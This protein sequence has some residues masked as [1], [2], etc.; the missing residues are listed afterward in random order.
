MET[1]DESNLRRGISDATNPIVA[2]ENCNLICLLNEANVD[3]PEECSTQPSNLSQPIQYD[4]G[5]PDHNTAPCYG[6][7]IELQLENGQPPVE[8]AQVVDDGI[9]KRKV[10][11]ATEIE[12]LNDHQITENNEIVATSE[13]DNLIS[14][15]A[16]DLLIFDSSTDT[17]GCRDQ[18]EE[19]GNNDANLSSCSLKSVDAIDH[20]TQN[21][22]Q[23]PS[24]GNNSKAIE[25]LGTDHTPQMPS[26]TFKNQAVLVSE[27]QE[28]EIGTG[29]S[30]DSKVIRIHVYR[31][32]LY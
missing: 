16:D 28:T 5:S 31:S 11:F 3:P 15:D 29:P 13:W 22:T 18:E 8:L 14:E 23:Y 30:L 25:D 17:V 12:L 7:K 24:N 10:L 19:L 26:G 32:F 2:R 1:L 9:E 20:C 4:T 27:N 6:I 21:A